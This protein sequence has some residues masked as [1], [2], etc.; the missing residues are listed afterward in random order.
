[1]TYAALYN[2]PIV[3]QATRLQS[4]SLAGL[5]LVPNSIALSIGSV[6]AG[7]YMRRTGR[8][9]RLNGFLAACMVFSGICILFITPNTPEWFTYVA[10][11]PNGFGCAGVLTCTLLA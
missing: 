4:S 3:F 1:M 7:I 2:Y 10:I 9:Y 5:H 6:A 11:V 8:Y